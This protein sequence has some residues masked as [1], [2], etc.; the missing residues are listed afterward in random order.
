MR[1]IKRM[2]NIQ[3]EINLEILESYEEDQSFELKAKE[4]K[5]HAEVEAA[6]R[7]DTFEDE[8]ELLT[9]LQDQPVV[10][11]ISMPQPED[12]KSIEPF[13]DNF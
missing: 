1:N 2:Q 11:N 9:A 6:N 13:A 8:P 4:M 5:A 10:S 7:L 3:K 12:F